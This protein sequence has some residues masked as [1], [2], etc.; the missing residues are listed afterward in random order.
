MGVE[1]V[2]GEKYRN[3]R[4]EYEVLEITGDGRLKV[5]YLQDG[6]LADL[7]KEQQARIIDNIQIEVAAQSL[8]TKDE[9]PAAT[10]TRSTVTSTR[11]TRSPSPERKKASSAPA[12]RRSNHEALAPVE[13]KP[14][15]P[16]RKTFTK[17]EVLRL[18]QHIGFGNPDGAFWFIGNSEL[19]ASDGNATLSERLALTEF[20]RE[21]IDA[22]I[23]KRRFLTDGGSFYGASSWQYANY[24]ATR[25]QLP[26]A[27]QTEDAR[28]NYFTN[29][30]GALDGDVLLTDI[31]SLPA[32]STSSAQWPYRETT[33][34][35]SPLYHTVLRDPQRFLDDQLTGRDA[36]VKRLS[37]LYAGLKVQKTAPRFVFCYG[38]SNWRY[39]KEIFPQVQV[40][41]EMELSPHLD[42]KRTTR[43][44]IGRDE[45]NGTLIILLP[46]LTPQEGVTYHYLDQLISLLQR[47]APAP[48]PNPPAPAIP[49]ASEPSEDGDSPP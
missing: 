47:L 2:V 38:R 7:D 46:V 11:Q 10:S 36:R 5:R 18:L 44:A 13:L 33:I 30:F 49:P 22:A 39:Y 43:S 37:E 45:D 21:F 34:T 9:R 3:R 15:V 31:L 17:P 8:L 27:E 6:V 48:K 23:Y 32:R 28:R 42:N 24:I 41:T 29:R 19:A 26:V 1:F 35:D 12:P 25:V 16:V 4:G 20:Q 14:L 40:Y